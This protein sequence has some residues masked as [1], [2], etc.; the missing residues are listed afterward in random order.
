VVDLIH[1]EGDLF[2]GLT[3]G[4]AADDVNG[5]VPCDLIKPG[6]QDGVRFE[7]GGVAG[8]FDEK[9]LR[10]LLGELWGANLPEGCIIDQIQVAVYERGEGV[11]RLFADELPEQIM[12]II[13]HVH[14]HIATAMQNPTNFFYDYRA[15]VAFRKSGI[16]NRG[17][18]QDTFTGF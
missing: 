11:L 12:V 16:E 7:F 15:S 9:G 5:G 8:K 18:S 4:F 1:L 3:P 6:G 17:Y 10:D 2:A 14:K 13:G